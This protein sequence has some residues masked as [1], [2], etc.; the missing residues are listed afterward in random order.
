MVLWFTGLPSVVQRAPI[1]KENNSLPN[2]QSYGFAAMSSSDSCCKCYQVK[3]TSGI[4]AGKSIVV[5][6][7]DIGG[8]SNQII[9]LTPGGG[10]G[11]H[12]SGCRAQYGTSW[13]V[14]PSYVFPFL[15]LRRH[16]LTQNVMHTRGDQNGG[17]NSSAA[18]AN[19]P[20]N[21]QG[22]CY[23]RFNWA[24]GDVNNWDMQYTQVTC[25]SRLTSISGCSA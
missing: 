15:S 5:Q 12:D 6:A 16:L 25:P 11:P 21:L 19:L 13:L 20:Q 2:W 4:A 7:I 23:W 3:W 22:G 18:C 14:D 1:R 9:I 24:H 10:V 8:S 17:V